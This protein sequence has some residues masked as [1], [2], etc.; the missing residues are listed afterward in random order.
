MITHFERLVRIDPG[1]L[2]ALLLMC[3]AA[4]GIHL[5]ATAAAGSWS[6]FAF[7]LVLLGVL[8]LLVRTD[9]STEMLLFIAFG[10]DW[11]ATGDEPSWWCLPAAL[12]L[13]VAHSCVT[14]VAS[15]PDAAPLPRDLVRRWVRNTMLVGAGCT[16]VGALLLAVRQTGVVATWWSVPVALAAL[17]V[18]AVALSET[19]RR[20]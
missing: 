2:R 17:A 5:C 1:R 16:A 3:V 19:V 8:A 7:V 20:G 4:F 11:W 12:C 14:L 18:V 6:W 9:G 13:L 15:G 10:L